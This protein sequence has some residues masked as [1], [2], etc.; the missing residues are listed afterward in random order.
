MT[1]S[2]FV[3]W[4]NRLGAG[5]LTIIVGTG[6]GAFA[7]KNCPLGRAFDQFFQMPGVCPGGCPGD[8][9]GWNWLAHYESSWVTTCTS[10]CWVVLRHYMKETQLVVEHHIWCN[11]IGYESLRTQWGIEKLTNSLDFCSLI[12]GTKTSIYKIWKLAQPF[13]LQ[14]PV[15]KL[16]SRGM[17][18]HACYSQKRCLKGAVFCTP[19][20]IE[21]KSLNNL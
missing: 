18:L 20:I 13:G 21:Q 9:R 5:H 11:L 14:S 4:S 10:N 7:N 6:G 8:A 12:P 1:T 2:T 17:Q 3:Y 19:Y 15:L 16:E